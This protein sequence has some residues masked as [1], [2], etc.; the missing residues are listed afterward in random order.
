M[1]LFFSSDIYSLYKKDILSAISLPQDYC[2][3][4]RYPKNLIPVEIISDVDSLIG[5]EGIIVYV[6]GNIY[7]QLEKDRNIL[8]FPIRN[9]R[10]KNAYFEKATGLV[11]IFLKLNRFIETKNI[12]TQELHNANHNLP[13]H[14]FIYKINEYS[15]S[16]VEWHDK[17]KKLV[18][19]DKYFQD[20]LFFNINVRHSE[21]NYREQVEISYDDTENS[22]YFELLEDK[23]YLLDLAIFNS[24][25][26]KSKFEDFS[27]KLSYAS[28]N[29]FITNPE[30]ISIGADADNRSYKIITKDI[31]S[32]SSSAYL[33]FQS[34]NKEKIIYDELLRLNIKRNNKKTLTYLFFSLLGIIGTFLLAFSAG[35][36]ASKGLNDSIMGLIL[37]SIIFMGS[38]A[39]GQFYY[40]NKRN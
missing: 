14:K 21:K 22:S 27:L 33:K 26:D 25:T 38:S 40:F 9:V 1:Y 36:L 28:E 39:V 31:K 35:K 7:T 11:H 32:V 2:L 37:V 12:P 8:F 15:S 19:F 10:V 4:F 13:P 30:S 24:S 3:H 23:N 18:S 16:I 5:K 20:H 34:F 6:S 17:V 29:F